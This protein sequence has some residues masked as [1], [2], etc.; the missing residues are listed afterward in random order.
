MVLTAESGTE[1]E[2]TISVSN[3]SKLS[4][5]LSYDS[6]AGSGKMKQLVGAQN[7]QLT[8]NGIDIERQSN[9]VTDAP[10]GITLQLTKEVKD[11]SITVTKK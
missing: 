2:M 11:A 6:K 5:L 4:D 7:A 8:V 1:S 10:Q 9:T 3:D